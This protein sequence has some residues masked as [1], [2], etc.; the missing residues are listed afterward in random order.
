[1]KFLD[2]AVSIE[3]MKHRNLDRGLEDLECIRSRSKVALL[4]SLPVD[5]TPDVLDVSSLPVQILLPVNDLNSK[6]IN[7]ELT[8][9]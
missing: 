5:D 4:G 1:M 7:V 2:L 8:W 6:S 3:S 9:R